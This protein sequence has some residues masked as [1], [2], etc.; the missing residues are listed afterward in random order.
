MHGDCAI[1]FNPGVSLHIYIYI[2]FFGSTLCTY[3]GRSWKMLPYPASTFRTNPRTKDDRSFSNL[4]RTNLNQPKI[5]LMAEVYSVHVFIIIVDIF[6][7]VYTRYMFDICIT[8][9]RYMYIILCVG[10]GTSKSRWCQWH[11]TY[12]DNTDLWDNV[13]IPIPHSPKPLHCMGPWIVRLGWVHGI[14]HVPPSL[15]AL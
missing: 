9:W 2:D 5:R 4:G 8:Y 10:L 11:M 12:D 1:Y 14:W 3:I 15:F 13:L 7:F 6:L